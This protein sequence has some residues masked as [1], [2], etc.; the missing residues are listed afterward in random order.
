M[1]KFV[2]KLI[3]QRATTI[4]AQ[5]MAAAELAALEQRLA[6]IHAPLRDRL[7]AYAQRISELE[8]D[9]AQKGKEN[10]ELIKAKILMVRKQLE[11]EK[12]LVTFN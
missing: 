7:Q 9:L 6:K 4:D 8:K 11:A 12:N 2:Q 1:D 10:R 3:S 5:Q